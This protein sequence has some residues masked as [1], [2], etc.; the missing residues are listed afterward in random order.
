[1]ATK[2]LFTPSVW[3]EDFYISIWPSQPVSPFVMYFPVDQPWSLGFWFKRDPMQVNEFSTIFD[4]RDYDY[5]SGLIININPGGT[6]QA[7]IS[8][9]YPIESISMVNSIN[10]SDDG[11]HFVVVSHGYGVMGASWYRLMVDNQLTV[12]SQVNRSNDFAETLCGSQQWLAQYDPNQCLY[13]DF[14]IASAIDGIF[15]LAKDITNGDP[16]L[17]KFYNNGN[18]IQFDPADFSAT[19]LFTNCDATPPNWSTDN[20]TFLANVNGPVHV[21]LN[22]VGVIAMEGG[23]GRATIATAAP[24]GI[25]QLGGSPPESWCW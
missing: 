9:S 5:L 13:L 12:G 6:L 21:A 24:P 22:N 10:I 2:A 19:G 7:D 14:C 15:Y 3:T 8:T 20:S 17:A 1:M 4:N 16:L 25:I 18:G 23:I 11:W